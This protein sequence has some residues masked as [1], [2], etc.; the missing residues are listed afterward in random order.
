[1]NLYLAPAEMPCAPLVEVSHACACQ[2]EEKQLSLESRASAVSS[3]IS[4]CLSQQ[5]S[6]VGL[7]WDRPPQL[8][9][10]ATYLTVPIPML[11][12]SDKP[13]NI[14]TRPPWRVSSLFPAGVQRSVQHALVQQGR[15]A[16]LRDLLPQQ[17]LLGRKSVHGGER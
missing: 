3:H 6:H 9:T 13:C 11:C 4:S 8:I 17:A 1:M 5:A 16:V 7:I 15:E 2:H 10:K 14:W 12:M